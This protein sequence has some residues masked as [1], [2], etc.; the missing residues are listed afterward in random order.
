MN[1]LIVEKRLKYLKINKL[2]TFTLINK[3]KNLYT[4]DIP[5]NCILFLFLFNF[6]FNY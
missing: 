4:I 2:Q 5:K 1:K 6:L 3:Q